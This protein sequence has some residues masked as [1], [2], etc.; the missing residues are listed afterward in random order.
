[1]THLWQREQ[2]EGALVMTSSSVESTACSVIQRQ[3]SA[4]LSASQEWPHDLPLETRLWLF[5]LEPSPLMSSMASSTVY[6]RWDNKRSIII[7][8]ERHVNSLNKILY[9][10]EHMVLTSVTNSLVIECECDCRC[11]YTYVHVH[12]LHIIWVFST[13]FYLF[14]LPGLLPQLSHSALRCHGDDPAAPA[15]GPLNQC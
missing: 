1:M 13:I 15:T 8:V 10:C 6:R 12:I 3:Q 5:W 14:V 2:F 7:I 4:W 9:E 11:I